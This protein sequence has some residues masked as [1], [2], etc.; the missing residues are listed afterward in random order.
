MDKEAVSRMFDEL[1]PAKF[2]ILE[3][4][5]QKAKELKTTAK[6]VEEK[7]KE[8]ALSYPYWQ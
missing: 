7:I 8:F 1:V 2:W 3:T 5:K 6:S 4:T